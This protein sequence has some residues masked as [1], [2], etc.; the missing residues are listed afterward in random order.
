LQNSRD[1]FFGGHA[2][3]TPYNFRVAELAGLRLL[4]LHP[5]LL[6]KWLVVE[7]EPDQFVFHTAGV[8]RATERGFQVVGTL[9]TTPEFYSSA[10]DGKA[11]GT[12]FSNYAPA[13]W[14]AWKRYVKRT[15]NAYQPWIDTWEHWNEPDGG[16]LQ[17]GPRQ[18]RFKLYMQMLEQTD[19]VI[20]E[21]DFGITLIGGAIVTPRRQFIHNMLQADGGSYLDYLSFHHYGRVP[22]A[23]WVEKMNM[24]RGFRAR[25]GGPLELW[26]TEGG[27]WLHTAPTWL[28]TSGLDNTGLESMAEG[29]ATLVKTMTMLKALGIRKHFHYPSQIHQAGHIVYRHGHNLADVNGI[30]HAQFGAHAAAVWL[31]EEAEGLHY[32]QRTVEG[33]K[34]SVAHFRRHG[35]PLLVAWSKQPVSSSLVREIAEADQKCLIYDM[36]GN[37]M[38]RPEKITR[39][40]VYFWMK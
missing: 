6:T 18:D 4:R 30:P 24:M 11:T 17:V 2:A 12:P 25:H 1:S 8:E 10:P 23:Q 26:H 21:E 15:I 37:N 28:K 31:L 13:N 9:G 7:P 16:F 39:F 32:E 19:Q 33:T 35:E 5:P 3:L 27:A 40:P 22:S 34:V 36:M 29:A 20:Q 14:K 38:D